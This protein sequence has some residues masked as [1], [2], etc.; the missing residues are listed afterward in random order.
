VQAALVIEQLPG[1][2]AHGTCELHAALVLAQ[3]P[4]DEQSEEL[5]H[6]TVASLAQVPR[7]SG[8]VPGF[9]LQL[10]FGGLLH[11]PV[12]RHCRFA[13]ACVVPL[14][15]CCDQGWPFCFEQVPGVVGQFAADAQSFCVQAWPPH[16]AVVVQA[17]VP[18]GQ[19]FCAQVPPVTAGQL[20]P[21]VQAL[22]VQG[23]VL[24][25]L[26]QS[27]AVE[28]AVTLSEQVF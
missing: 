4:I 20:P 14:Q 3:V 12:V 23:P 5:R 19:V 22:V 21:V 10:E 8:Q 7:I 28:H 15:G 25:M 13:F 27:V 26:V 9:A 16:C 17:V 24:P 11:V 6:F 18:L 1:T 2:L